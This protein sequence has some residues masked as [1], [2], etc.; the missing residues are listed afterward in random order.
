M[1]RPLAI[2]WVRRSCLFSSSTSWNWTDELSGIGAR[3]LRTSV[4]RVELVVW[5]PTG[6][7]GFSSCEGIC[8]GVAVGERR[9]LERFEVVGVMKTSSSLLGVGTGQVEMPLLCISL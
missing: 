2:P 9:P 4:A 3:I 7:L 5:F 8:A 1:S 6:W